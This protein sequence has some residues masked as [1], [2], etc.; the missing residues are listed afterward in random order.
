MKESNSG[1]R[2]PQAEIFAVLERLL[3]AEAVQVS[4]QVEKLVADG[5]NE[6]ALARLKEYDA[7]LGGIGIYTITD[8]KPSGIY[9]AFSYV[10]NPLRSP[11]V[12]N[13]TRQMVH[14]SCAYLEELLKKIVRTWPWEKAI[15]GKLPLGTLVRRIVKRLPKTLYEDLNWLSQKICNPAKHHFNMEDDQQEPEHFFTVGE[16]IAVYLIVRKLGLEV[17]KLSGK[18]I[19]E[20]QKMYTY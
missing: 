7:T 5:Q 9:R 1:E 19:E 8:K 18:S 20:L 10:E 4:E 15:D 12:E 6:T 2:A 16:A 14:A 17:E 11:G 3:G 13:Q